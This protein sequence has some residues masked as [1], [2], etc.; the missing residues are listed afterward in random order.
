MKK[1]AVFV[2]G[3]TEQIFA[4]E[5][6]RHIFGHAKVAIE[7]LRFSGKEGSRRIRTI[8]SVDAA[9]FTEY[10]FR[11]YDCQGGNENST[12][13]SDIREQFLGLLRESFSYIVGIRDVYPL[14]DIELLKSNINL[15]LP[16]NPALPVKIFLAI[17]E[18][19]S[20]FLAEENHYPLIDESL[21]VSHVNSIIGFDITTASTESVNH[22]SFALKQIYQI[23]GKDYNKKKWEVERTVYVLDYENLYLNVRNRN[24][25]LNEL[26]TCLDGLIP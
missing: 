14:L 9:P 15:K 24:N 17:R 21:T 26:L 6:V 4:D 1:V 8:R 18:I 5:L 22:P 7:E 16:N 23:A 25:S 13:K 11:I 19:E 2:E 3:Q 12:V 20:W 10:L